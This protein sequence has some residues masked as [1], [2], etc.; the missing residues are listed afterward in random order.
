[1]TLIDSGDFSAKFCE[2]LK[3]FYVCFVGFVCMYVMN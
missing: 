1:M 3:K 2:N